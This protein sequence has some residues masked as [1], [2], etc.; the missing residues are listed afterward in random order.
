MPF[1]NKNDGN[2]NFQSST[3]TLDGSPHS[4]HIIDRTSN[5]LNVA[6]SPNARYL[7]A[8]VAPDLSINS[9]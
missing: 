9:W 8:S 2:L 6:L 5:G 3:D 4:S 1:I 7:G